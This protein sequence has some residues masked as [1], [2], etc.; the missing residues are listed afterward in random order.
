MLTMLEIKRCPFCG[1]KAEFLTKSNTS[2]HT[3]VGFEFV[4]RCA[5]CKIESSRTCRVHFHLNND[6]EIKPTTDQRNKA[7]DFWNKR[8]ENA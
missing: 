2:S 3:D 7:I 6:G 5:E 8:A 4:I 1:G